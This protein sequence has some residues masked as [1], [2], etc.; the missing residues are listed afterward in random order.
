MALSAQPLAATR[1]EAGYLRRNRYD[2][3]FRFD[4]LHAEICP[5]QIGD[6]GVVDSDAFSHHQRRARFHHSGDFGYLE[7]LLVAPRE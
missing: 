7:T 2:E 5:E 3:G 1:V 6:L 4:A